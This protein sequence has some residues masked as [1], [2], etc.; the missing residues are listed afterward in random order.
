MRAI[1]KNA[2]KVGEL[3]H[4]FMNGDNVDIETVD[5]F[6]PD[7]YIVKE[8]EWRLYNAKEALY[9]LHHSEPDYKVW[10]RDARQLTTFITRGNDK[11][12]PHENDGLSYEKILEKIKADEDFKF[13]S[14]EDTY[15]LK[16][17]RT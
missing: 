14:R 16:K 3:A 9:D 5:K 17:A 2:W 4:Q 8:A 11:C 15:Q 1:V 12:Q 13:Y 7:A 10:K 6:Y